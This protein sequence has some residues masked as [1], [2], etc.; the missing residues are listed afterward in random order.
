MKA[1]DAAAN[2]LMMTMMTITTMTWRQT[3]PDGRQVDRRG[4]NRS[5]R[6]AE[7]IHFTY[8]NRQQQWQHNTER[9][10]YYY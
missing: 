10:Y 7:T 1:A 2:H 3:S 4:R 8:C 6:S 9:Y 5:R